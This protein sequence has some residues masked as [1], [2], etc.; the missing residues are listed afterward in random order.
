MTLSAYAENAA[1]APRK[2]HGAKRAA[3]QKNHADG[4]KRAATGPKREAQQAAKAKKA[5]VHAL[6]TMDRAQESARPKDY[7]RDLQV[8]SSPEIVD[9]GVLLSESFDTSIPAGWAVVDNAGSGVVWTNL[10]G[11]TEPGNWTGGSGDLG[12][13]SSD[14]FGRAEFDTELQTPVIDLSSSVAP[15]SL[16]FNANYQNFAGLDFFDVDVSTNGAA[17]PWTNLLT[18][19]EDHGT[20]DGTPGVAVNLDIAS[21]VGQANVMFRFHYYDPNQGDWDWYAMVDDVVVTATAGNGPPPVEVPTLSE[22]G[23]G[24]LALLLAGAGFLALR[25]QA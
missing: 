9:G 21:V 10:A 7:S 15:A 5:A 12:C 4:A 22:V 6:R 2:G 14:R 11:C 23:L 8:Q 16:T 3:A 1:P 25:R 17:G 20:S 18:W 13:V 19:N 24:G